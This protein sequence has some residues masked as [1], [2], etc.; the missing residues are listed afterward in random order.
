MTMRRARR[1]ESGAGPSPERPGR[2]VAIVPAAGRGARMGTRRPK[3]YLEIAGVPLLVHTLRVLGRAPVVAGTVVVVPATEIAATRSL[4]RRF[5]V[6]GVLLVVAGGARRQESVRFGLQAAPADVDWILVH[7]A[8]RPFITAELV[9]RVLAAAEVSGAATCGL[10][11]RETV[12]RVHEDLVE[13]TLDR[14]GLWLVQTP[15]AFKRDLLWAA[16]EKARRD[17]FTGTDDAVLVERAGGRVSM[18][19]GLPGNLKIT[20]PEDLETARLWTRRLG[21]SLREGARVGAPARPR[22]RGRERHRARAGW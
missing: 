2:A 20:T 7:D 1:P 19:P 6:P 17:G 13:S 15:Q 9:G 10:A 21:A 8:V 11:V 5:E 12:K 14:E 22:R 4:L 16:H 18:V 3:Q